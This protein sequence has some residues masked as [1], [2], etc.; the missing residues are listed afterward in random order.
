M[1]RHPSRRQL[2]GLLHLAPKDV[3]AVNEAPSPRPLPMMTPLC[4]LR[5]Q[6]SLLPIRS[7]TRCWYD[8]SRYRY[9]PLYAG[10]RFSWF[11]HLHQHWF[12]PG[13]RRSSTG[14]CTGAAL[15]PGTGFRRNHRDLTSPR[16][17][18][19]N[20]E[21]FALLA[22]TVPELR[23][24]AS[25]VYGINVNL[26]SA[27]RCEHARLVEAFKAATTQAETQ[28]RVDATAET[29]GEAV[30][31]QGADWMSLIHQFKAKYGQF[32]HD[33]TLLFQSSHEV[34]EENSRTV[35]SKRKHWLTHSISKKK[36]ANVP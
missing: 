10:Y 11:C 33:N 26:G 5:C 32:L 19:K 9:T 34:F 1:H 27:H 22:G 30:V 28:L 16:H 25:D 21:T 36:R 14:A 17:I 35:I 3:S 2:R 6:L 15:P 13:H 20:Q 24:A 7:C 12:L 31:M 8:F 4:S 23:D 29:H 18:G